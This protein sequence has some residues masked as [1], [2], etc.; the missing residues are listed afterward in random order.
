MPKFKHALVK[1]SRMDMFAQVII[2]II[3][4]SFALITLLPFIYIFAGSFATDRE[5]I[6]RPFFLFQ[7]GS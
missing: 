4:G 3:V 1:R 2:Y 6:E 7:V 5:L